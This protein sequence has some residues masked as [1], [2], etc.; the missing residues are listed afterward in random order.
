MF[1]KLF[2]VKDPENMVRIVIEG[3]YPAS[4]LDAPDDRGSET[5]NRDRVVKVRLAMRY[6]TT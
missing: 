2:F 6:A 5:T 3:L 4:Y 1:S